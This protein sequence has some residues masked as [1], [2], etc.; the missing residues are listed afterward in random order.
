LDNRRSG[1]GEF[2]KLERIEV[3]KGEARIGAAN[4]GHE[5]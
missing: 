5:G 1:S 4:A 3:G 2:A